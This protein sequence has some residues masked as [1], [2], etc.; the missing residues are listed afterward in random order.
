MKK[1]IYD[2]QGML[3]VLGFLYFWLRAGEL[4]CQVLGVGL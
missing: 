3:M 1:F 4:L 2:I